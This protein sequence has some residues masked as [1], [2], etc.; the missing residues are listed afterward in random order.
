[1]GAG[2]GDG[3]RA[4]EVI[5]SAPLEDG[6]GRRHGDTILGGR[7]DREP[8]W[9]VGEEVYAADFLWRG[10]TIGERGTLGHF[11]V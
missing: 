4:I 10:R 11:P 9:G 5:G 7:D 1:V 3:G 8:G 2:E 6:E